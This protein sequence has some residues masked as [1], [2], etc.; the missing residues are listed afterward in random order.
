LQED[1][2]ELADALAEEHNYFLSGDADEDGV[3]NK[4]LAYVYVHV[5]A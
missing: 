3:L 5:L 4:V 1:S 2:P